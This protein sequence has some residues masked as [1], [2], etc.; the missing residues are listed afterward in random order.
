MNPARV[1]L[2]FRLGLGVRVQ[3]HESCSCG[4]SG[5]KQWEMARCRNDKSSIEEHRMGRAHK[6]RQGP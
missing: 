2:G 4:I 3:G 5:A 1:E 6:P